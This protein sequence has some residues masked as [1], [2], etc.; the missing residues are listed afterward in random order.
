MHND[1]ISSELR[2]KQGEKQNPVN[3][4]LGVGQEDQDK[5]WALT[6]M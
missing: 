6:Q 5:L 3:T 1:K 4:F 2:N